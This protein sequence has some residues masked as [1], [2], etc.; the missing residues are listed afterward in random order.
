MQKRR[1]AEIGRC[2]GDENLREHAKDDDPQHEAIPPRI[3][4]A[5]GDFLIEGGA[6]EMFRL[7]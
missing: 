2:D 4:G 3:T 5:H 7:Q 6:N 1:R